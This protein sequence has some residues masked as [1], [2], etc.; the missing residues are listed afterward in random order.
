MSDPAISYVVDM[1]GSAFPSA[2]PHYIFLPGEF[3]EE[4]VE[5]YKSL[6]RMYIIP[7][8]PAENHRGLVELIARLHDEKGEK[9]RELVAEMFSKHKESEMR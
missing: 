2:R 7:Y 5:I 8:D 6:K 9:E 4:H 1:F 3:P